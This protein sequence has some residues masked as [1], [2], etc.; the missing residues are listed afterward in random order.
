MGQRSRALDLEEKQQTWQRAQYE[1]QRQQ[2]LAAAGQLQSLLKENR[3]DSTDS[4]LAFMEKYPQ[5]MT[6][7]ITAKLFGGYMDQLEKVDRI[8]NMARESALA[9]E[10]AKRNS[11]EAQYWTKTGHDIFEVDP[12]LLPSYRATLDDNGIATQATSEF[13]KSTGLR[14]KINART[15][16]EDVMPKPFSI[17]V[18]GKTVNGLVNPKTGHFVANKTNKETDLRVKL[19]EQQYAKLA[20]EERVL[21]RAAASAPQDS[22]T[23]VQR[24]T[25]RRQREDLRNE[26][27]SLKSTDKSTTTTDPTDPLGLGIK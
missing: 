3:V 24:D 20:E 26:I 14:E 23:A 1:Q 5:V 15:V 27:D 4:G 13:M 22:K 2:V 8:K 25:I 12:D 19:L 6:N 21:D 7:P 16:K 11:L 9:K 17:D 10:T 18:D